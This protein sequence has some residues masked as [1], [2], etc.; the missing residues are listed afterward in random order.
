MPEPKLRGLLSRGG[1]SP[2][3]R[4]KNSSIGSLEPLRGDRCAVV[5]MFTTT[6]MVLLAMAENDGGRPS[7]AGLLAASALDPSLL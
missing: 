7:N 3:K 5:E 4:L 1:A 6:G 2:K